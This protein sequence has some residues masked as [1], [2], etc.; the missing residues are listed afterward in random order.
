MKKGILFCLSLLL[1]I[2]TLWGQGI[3]CGTTEMMEQL[4]KTHPELL[5]EKRIL[6]AQVASKMYSQKKRSISKTLGD[7]KIVQI[8]VV[9]HII[10]QSNSTDPVSN[11]RIIKG[12]NM[13]NDMLKFVDL[14]S[15]A[16]PTIKQDIEI[17]LVLA[18]QGIDRVDKTY[19]YADGSIY[20]AIYRYINQSSI[21]YSSLDQVNSN[22]MVD[23]ILDD[24]DNINI[25]NGLTFPVEKYCNIYIVDEI[26]GPVGGFASMPV[27]SKLRSDGIVFES[28]YLGTSIDN[29]KVFIHELGHYL[30]LYHTFGKVNKAEP[31]SNC[32]R[33]VYCD[34]SADPKNPIL[35]SD[36]VCDTPIDFTSDNTCNLSLQCT[37]DAKLDPNDAA[38]HNPYMADQQEDIHNY[39]DYSGLPC[40]SHFTKGQ[41]QRMINALTDDNLRGH[42]VCGADNNN[43]A[44]ENPCSIPLT[45]SFDIT[46]GISNATAGVQ[47]EFL[48]TSTQSG[49]PIPT[50]YAFQWNFGDGTTSTS[51]ADQS[52]THLYTQ[53]KLYDI[54]IMA[55]NS[56]VS[57][58]RIFTKTINVPCPINPTFTVNGAI[59][60]SSVSAQVGDK[61]TFNN[62]SI[63]A[64]SYSWLLDGKSVGV[65][66]TAL[67]YTFN[68]ATAS[69]LQLVVSNGTCSLT[70]SGLLV[71]VG[72][73]CPG[74]TGNEQNNWYFGYG[75]GITFNT[76]PPSAVSQSSIYTLEGSASISDGNGNLLFYTNGVTV[77]N[78]QHKVMTNG[79]GLKGDDNSTQSSIIVPNPSPNKKN[80]YYIFTAKNLSGT[81]FG[82]IHYYE[83]D[84]SKGDPDP[85]SGNHLGELLPI[86]KELLASST[87]Q[88]A[89]I[90]GLNNCMYVVAHGYGLNNDKIFVFTITENGLQ[91]GYK[92]FTL[93][94]IHEQLSGGSGQMKFSSNGEILAIPKLSND[95]HPSKID[96]FKFDKSTGT[97]TNLIFTY[98]LGLWTSGDGYPYGLEFS[99]NG[100]LLYYTTTH[101]L[102]QIDISLGINQKSI[103]VASNVDGQLQLGPDNKIYVKNGFNLSV[104]ESPNLP[105][106]QCSFIEDAIKLRVSNIS[107]GLPNFVA[108]FQADKPQIVAD[109]CYKSNA[110]S[111]IPLIAD[112]SLLPN[113]SLKWSVIEQSTTQPVSIADE[114]NNTAKLYVSEEG[115]VKVRLDKT[116][117]CGNTFT[118]KDIK[119][120]STCGAL[121]CPDVDVKSTCP[122][123]VDENERFNF[124]FELKSINE[125]DINKLILEAI[126]NSSETYFVLENIVVNG[127]TINGFPDYVDYK[128][129]VKNVDGLKIYTVQLWGHYKTDATKTIDQHFFIQFTN[130]CL[131]DRTIIFIPMEIRKNCWE[132]RTPTIESCNHHTKIEDGK[133]YSAHLCV[134]ELKDVHK[135]SFAF[136]YDKDLFEPFL[137]NNLQLEYGWK[138]TS[139]HIDANIG[140]IT[141]TAEVDLTTPLDHYIKA[142]IN[143][144]DNDGDISLKSTIA[145]ISLISKNS[146][147]HCN[148]AIFA[149]DK[150]DFFDVNGNIID[151]S[152]INCR[153]GY[154][155][156][157][158]YGDGGCNCIDLIGHLFKYENVQTHYWTI[159]GPKIEY[160]GTNGWPS[161]YLISDGL[162]I[163]TNVIP[164]GTTNTT[165]TING[166]KIPATY[167]EN[168]G[169]YFNRTEKDAVFIPQNI[170][171]NVTD[172]DFMVEAR[173]NVNKIN[174]LTT[175]QIAT[176]LT[177]NG[178][179][180][181]A[182]A[183]SGG[184]VFGLNNVGLL[185]LVY[186]NNILVSTKALDN[187]MC[188]HVAF[189]VDKNSSTGKDKLSLFIDGVLD[190]QTE[191]TS[192]AISK[193]KGLQLGGEGYAITGSITP[194][195]IEGIVNELRIWSRLKPVEEI[196]AFKEVYANGNELGLV[197]YWRLNELGGQAIIDYTANAL[198][199]F[200]GSNNTVETI[201]PS[202]SI[203]CVKSGLF[204][205]PSEED[206]VTIPYNT[207]QANF[208]NGDF[209]IEA[210][211]KTNDLYY[212]GLRNTCSILTNNGYPIVN[213][214]NSIGF[215][216]GLNN[217]G[218]VQLLVSDVV[219]TQGEVDDGE[220]HYIAVTL[221]KG[222]GIYGRD[223]ISIYID[224][225]LDVQR[226]V[227]SRSNVTNK[228]LQISGQG[229]GVC[230]WLKPDF[231]DGTIGELRIWNVAKSQTEIY[232][233]KNNLFYGDEPNLIGYWKMDN[234]G[235]IGQ[236]VKDYSILANN[237]VLGT[238]S[239]VET[240]DPVITEMCSA[241][242]C[243]TPTS[244]FEDRDRDAY[245]N[246]N[247]EAKLCSQPVRFVTDKTDC[248]D[249]NATIHPGAPE[250]C[251]KLDND[252]DGIVETPCIPEC[253]TI[254]AAF[255][256]SAVC[257]YQNTSFWSTSNYKYSSFEW[258][259]DGVSKNTG[260]NMN[261][262]FMSE[263]NHT[264][265]LVAMSA[266]EGCQQTATKQINIPTFGPIKGPTSICNKETGVGFGLNTTLTGAF[267]NWAVWGSCTKIDN[268]GTSAKI[269]FGDGI[270]TG[271][272]VVVSTTYNKTCYVISTFPLTV[273]ACST[274]IPVSTVP[275]TCTT[276][277]LNATDWSLLNNWNDKT[278][279]STITSSTD[280]IVANHRA[281]GEDYFWLVKSIGQLD[282]KSTKSYSV[283]FNIKDNNKTVHSRSLDVT[284]ASSLNYD[285]P[286]VSQTS[287]SVYGITTS[288]YSK[289]QA[290][291]TVTQDGKYY[292]CIKVNMASQPTESTSYTINDLKLCETASTTKAFELSSYPNPFSQDVKIDIT[293]KI[294]EES[295]LMTVTDIV[296]K[297][298]FSSEITGNY[299]LNFGSDWA[300]GVY[301]VTL[302]NAHSSETFKLVK[303][304]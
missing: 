144:K 268:T 17:Q 151:L 163:E 76:I 125:I 218:R 25:R 161:A 190:K 219:V 212:H 143:Y 77:Y 65:L 217:A 164:S 228:N 185:E 270:K 1:I 13:L 152:Q 299:S 121:V 79:T 245:G 85:I 27:T 75:N 64:I 166:M 222:A 168:Q 31:F 206:V 78:S 111:F 229:D 136:K 215:C 59:P 278:A 171:Y 243:A 153:N 295:Y 69:T 257:P 45:L 58:T 110:I 247:V 304:K 94:S 6:D 293:S 26:I 238:S 232:N 221:K 187:G 282:L 180:N 177:N 230:D 142:D 53:G 233:S 275:G 226:D 86:E 175:N 204:F 208:V 15:P 91:S 131:S 132:L 140:Q 235:I 36:D 68:N 14:V 127:H 28:K 193:I 9:F 170:K 283:E 225:K 298:V 251:D 87:E 259:V 192:V 201:D 242:P 194:S 117:P 197:G 279:G 50:N 200:R 265:K 234:E 150:V 30:N 205:N 33:E 286:L 138:L 7:H 210:T 213:N 262:T 82:G 256:N 276:V 116:S 20:G 57:C 135:I 189:S 253:K 73:N 109:E 81:S 273:G 130:G 129:M 93:G 252:C 48:N 105:G 264:V 113:E 90:K 160:A 244:Y 122:I 199:G 281:Y 32:Q 258:F 188:H 267:F 159:R 207:N 97:I 112:V 44:C 39:M 29:A 178:K 62:T 236:T 301:V 46:G 167:V 43:L 124:Q 40:M 196:N 255:D 271:D 74:Y 133:M 101:G 280:G 174:Y 156:T 155:C 291:L 227:N 239:I 184:F 12:L 240:V 288:S 103:C 8:P 19:K 285:G 284:F 224:G 214:W 249:A 88:L 104:I 107:S 272:K 16:D 55:T 147:V 49:N 169:T 66:N 149:E 260:T 203:M 99:P 96:F 134:I 119:I 146:S 114:T 42:L 145:R 241:K 294:V 246:K 5:K 37:C 106:S 11:E 137:E 128:N 98:D 126:N 296:G 70:T 172:N 300:A 211:V 89:A 202:S 23:E 52:V 274:D 179:V 71:D 123:W 303:L 60:S 95:N 216:F 254:S 223:A 191:V 72:N 292:L 67:D 38:D 237:G 266:S 186:G 21:Q 173:I 35:F 34:G 154:S 182:T 297:T 289:V 80:L 183:S 83:V 118:V 176:I 120:S 18:Q 115:T 54:T 22:N 10:Q 290:P 84:M 141:G 41:A 100:K 162:Q 250:I 102:F 2:Q 263:G 139:I 47:L 24:A 220:C 63:G 287:Y 165:V 302:Q 248:N 108:N 209:T 269:D 92:S 198:H 56:E 261:Y 181:N 61:L 51:S 157:W 231:F 148:D 195:P 277:N 3:G 4:Y 158:D